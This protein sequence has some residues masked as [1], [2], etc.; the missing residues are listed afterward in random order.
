[1][2]FPPSGNM[3]SNLYVSFYPKGMTPQPHVGHS[4]GWSQGW[5]PGSPCNLIIT[6]HRVCHLPHDYIFFIHLLIEE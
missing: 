2:R 6:S 4:L 1:M 5:E 3:L